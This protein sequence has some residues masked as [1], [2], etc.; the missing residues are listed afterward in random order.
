MREGGRRERETEKGGKEK[1]GERERE[2]EGGREG[3]TCR[4]REHGIQYTL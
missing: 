1:G 3:G 4:K 2:R